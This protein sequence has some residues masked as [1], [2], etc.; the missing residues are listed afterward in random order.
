M[1]L[2][3]AGFVRVGPPKTASTTLDH[4]L[5]RPALCERRWSP[6][7]QDQHSIL[8]PPQ[9]ESYFSFASVRNP[10]DRA[11][12]L[13]AHSQSPRSFV[14]DGTYPMSFEEF[15]LE[16]QPQAIWFYRLSQSEMLAP[17]HLDTVVRVDHL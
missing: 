11:V 9:A 13:W 17:I 16:Y 1:I 3:G 10:F 5:P 14:A 2:L 4:W 15:I 12:S 6:E 8:I 7:R